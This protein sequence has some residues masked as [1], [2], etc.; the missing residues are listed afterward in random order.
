MTSRGACETLTWLY[1]M[2]PEHRAL[3]ARADRR[4]ARNCAIVAV[5]VGYMDFGL[6]LR[7]GEV[8]FV[9]GAIVGAALCGLCL[10]TWQPPRRIVWALAAAIVIDMALYAAG[11]A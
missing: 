8:R 10:R 2:R 11:P 5:A 3:V 4:L 1:T 9:A 7:T 6:A